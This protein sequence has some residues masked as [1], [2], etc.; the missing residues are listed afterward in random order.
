V[1]EGL[2]RDLDAPEPQHHFLTTGRPVDFGVLGRRFLG[3]E[4]ESVE[5]FSWIVTA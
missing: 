1:R 2:E 5:Q 3:P 4:V